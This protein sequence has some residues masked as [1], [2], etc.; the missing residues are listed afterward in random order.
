MT[1]KKF[2]RAVGVVVALAAVA[3]PVVAAAVHPTSSSVVALESG[4]RW[5]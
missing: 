3:A 2:A 1:N 5:S 4:S